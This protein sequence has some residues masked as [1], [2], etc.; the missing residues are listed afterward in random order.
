MYENDEESS[1][2]E[3]SCKRRVISTTTKIDKILVKSVL[4]RYA[5]WTMQLFGTFGV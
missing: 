3:Q 2:M 1:Q 5:N 4:F